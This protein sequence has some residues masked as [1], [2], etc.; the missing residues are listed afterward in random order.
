MNIKKEVYDRCRN[1]L[2]RELSDLNYKKIRNRTDI[3]RL[4]K[5]Q[6]ILKSQIGE[7]LRLK[8]LLNN[9]NK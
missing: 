2:E 7:M 8:N 1:I 9:K 5:E 4:A 6:R 3:N